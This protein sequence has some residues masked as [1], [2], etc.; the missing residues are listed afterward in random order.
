MISCACSIVLRSE[1]EELK[2]RV[3]KWLAHWLGYKYRTSRRG[4]ETIG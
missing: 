3:A 1:L 2:P 4:M